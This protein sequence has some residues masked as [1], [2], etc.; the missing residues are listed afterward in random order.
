MM[1]SLVRCAPLALASPAGCPE[2]TML[3][4]GPLTLSCPWFRSIV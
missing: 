1:G 2:L 4:P 3:T